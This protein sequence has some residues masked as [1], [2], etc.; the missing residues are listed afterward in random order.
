MASFDARTE[1]RISKVG[2]TPIMFPVAEAGWLGAFHTA[3]FLGQVLDRRARVEPRWLHH[4]RS[5]GAFDGPRRSSGRGV[6]NAGL[7]EGTGFIAHD[8]N[9]ASR[10]PSRNPRTLRSAHIRHFPRGHRL[11]L[12]RAPQGR[13]SVRYEQFIRCFRRP[14]RGLRPPALGPDQAQVLR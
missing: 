9:M 13:V 11:A 14:E 4:L 7:A 1:K 6:T 3:Q 12:A 2:T 8:Q 10:A 5:S